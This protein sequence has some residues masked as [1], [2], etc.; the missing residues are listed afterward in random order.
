MSISDLILLLE[1][2]SVCGLAYCNIK[3]IKRIRVLEKE[4]SKIEDLESC[5]EFNQEVISNLLI[6]KVKEKGVKENE[7]K[8]QSKQ[9]EEA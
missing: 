5:V 3:T 2:I 4:I 1:C 6:E 9:S 8:I 7:S